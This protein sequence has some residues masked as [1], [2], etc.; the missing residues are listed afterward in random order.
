MEKATQSFLM[1]IIT[2]LL[3][4]ACSKE[5]R[6]KRQLTGSWTIT[7]VVTV[8]TVNNGSPTTDTDNSETVTT[9]E[10]DGSGT[11]SS[12]G[13]GTN[14]FPNEFTWSNTDETL[15]IVDTKNSITTIYDILEHS[16]KEMVLNT[17]SSETISGDTYNYDITITMN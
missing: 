3:L 7:E 15:T 1:V 11:A 12:S 10:K 8:T 9:F 4:T 5:K 13:S 6:I 17:T 16:K 14:P 2:V